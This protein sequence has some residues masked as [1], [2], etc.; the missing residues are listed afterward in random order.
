MWSKNLFHE[1]V[2]FSINVTVFFSRRKLSQWKNMALNKIA[3]RATLQK[4][5]GRT[6]W[7]NYYDKMTNKTPMRMETYSMLFHDWEHGYSVPNL[8]VQPENAIDDM[9]SVD[10]VWKYR[11]TWPLFLFSSIHQR[12]FLLLSSIVVLLISIQWP[13]TIDVFKM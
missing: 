1:M 9:T 6:R 7:K 10:E 8:Q 2:F 4:K 12:V 5:G 13:C 3:S 11:G